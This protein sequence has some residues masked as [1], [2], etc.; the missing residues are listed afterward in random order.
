MFLKLKMLLIK[1][2]HYFVWI[3]VF[4]KSCQMRSFSKKKMP[5]FV[6]FIQNNQKMQ[7]YAGIWWINDAWKEQNWV[8]Q[9]SKYTFNIFNNLLIIRNY[10]NK[11]S[12]T[13]NKNSNYYQYSEKYNFWQRNEMRT[14]FQSRYSQ[15]TWKDLCDVSFQCKRCGI[16]I[17]CCVSR[18]MCLRWSNLN[19]S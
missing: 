14:K 3:K 9:T 17:L 6:A 18:A 16:C 11:N 15:Q 8:L 7:R 13:D 4:K 1:M 12:F 5:V 2:D 19:W 10:R